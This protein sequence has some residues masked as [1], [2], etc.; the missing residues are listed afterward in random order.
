MRVGLART[1][2]LCLVD[3]LTAECAYLRLCVSRADADDW[4]DADV[5]NLLGD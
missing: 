5:G 4:G 2:E 1:E 3:D